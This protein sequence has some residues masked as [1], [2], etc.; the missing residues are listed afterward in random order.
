MGTGLDQHDEQEDGVG[1]GEGTAGE[2]ADDDGRSDE[3]E[4]DQPAGDDAQDHS[5]GNRGSARTCR[6]VELGVEIKI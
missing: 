3:R 2:G 6:G 4:D 1:C 5:H